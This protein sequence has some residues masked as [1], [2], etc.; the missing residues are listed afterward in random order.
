MYSRYTFSNERRNKS[1]FFHSNA[2]KNVNA[3]QKKKL[4]ELFTGQLIDCFH[5][6]V[7]SRDDIVKR[8]QYAWLRP[9]TEQ[10]PRAVSTI[11]IINYG[12]KRLSIFLRNLDFTMFER[13]A[14]YIIHV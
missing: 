5:L 12:K 14:F 4:F 9:I 10:S 13:N 3:K 7:V 1:I 8:F 11:I 6:A 2:H